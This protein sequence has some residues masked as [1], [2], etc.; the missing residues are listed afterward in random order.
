[1]SSNVDIYARNLEVTP[2][3]RDHVEKKAD[4]L[5]RFLREIDETRV[6]LTHVKSA[7]NVADR[8]VAQITVRGKRLLLRVEE[9]NEDLLAAFDAALDKMKR[10]IDRYKGKHYH[11]RGDGRSA[12]EVT[13]A[14]TSS[15]AETGAGSIVRRKHFVVEPMTE[16]EAIDQMKNVGHENF[17]IFFNIETGVLNV[18]YQRRDGDYGVLEPEVR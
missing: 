18:L 17:F 5:Q 15:E 2:R 7:R 3:I 9:R 4:K 8:N 12:A 1:M 10:Q 16:Q 11:D 6:D 14:L 13:A